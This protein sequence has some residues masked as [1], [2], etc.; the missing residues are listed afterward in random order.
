M[1][2]IVLCLLGIVFLSSFGG[3]DKPTRYVFHKFNIQTADK[4]TI[5]T[6][7]VNEMYDVD[8]KLLIT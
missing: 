1:K 2:K 6:G 3:N 4:Y 7:P 8:G 5:S